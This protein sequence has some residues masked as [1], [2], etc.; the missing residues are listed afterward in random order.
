MILIGT[1]S[2]GVVSIR[3]S[4]AYRHIS[5]PMNVGCFSSIKIGLEVGLARNL[6]VAEALE[7]DPAPSHIFFLDDDVIPIT[8]NPIRQLIKHDEPIVSGVYFTKSEFSEPV[9]L[10]GPS[11]GTLKYVPGTGLHE[12][13]VPSM[14]IC[15]IQTDV[16]RRIA[17]N[18]DIGTDKLG[19]PRWYYTAGDEPGEIDHT[20]DAWFCAN[21]RKAGYKCLV[22]TSP[23]AF[24]W[25]WDEKSKVAFPIPQWEEF[26]KSNTLSW[27]VPDGNTLDQLRH[28]H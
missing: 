6:I 4:A 21:A 16:F 1:P 13:C 14:G 26:Q 9:A 17:E 19:N 15:L 25:H 11:E 20:E 24:A 28:T 2:F 7:M 12:V 10:L 8:N 22:D 27:E 5:A 23:H 18:C 3:W